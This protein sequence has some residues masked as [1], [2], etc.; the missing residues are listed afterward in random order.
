MKD[1]LDKAVAL[2]GVDKVNLPVIEQILIGKPKTFGEKEAIH[3][4]V[5]ILKSCHSYIILK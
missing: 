5:E 3:P 4:N 1:L 2:E